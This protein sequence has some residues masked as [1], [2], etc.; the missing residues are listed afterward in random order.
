L[1]AGFAMHGK[2]SGSGQLRFFGWAEP[3]QAK[4]GQ[5]ACVT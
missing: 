4:A 5:K 3:F 2:G 1:L